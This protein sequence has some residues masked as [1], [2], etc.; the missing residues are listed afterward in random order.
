MS[1]LI[2][3]RRTAMWIEQPDNPT[4]GLSETASVPG[5]RRCP[6]GDDF[7]D[8]MA[9]YE[10]NYIRLRRL[11]PNLAEVSGHQVSR[12]PGCMDLHLDVLERHRY[13]GVV[14]LTYYFAGDA[15]AGASAPMND[16]DPDLYLRIYFDAQVAEA[17]GRRQSR[18]PRLR[19][20]GQGEL[21]GRWRLNRFLFKWL[22]YCLVRG[23]RFE[24]PVPEH[25]G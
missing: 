18:S 23:H 9:L 1:S 15:S 16:R 19:A 14:R 3:V 13:T 4:A 2:G 20:P 5:P 12:V 6:C 7:S 10:E 11:V 24:G 21:L 22:G 17:T 8:L 25:G